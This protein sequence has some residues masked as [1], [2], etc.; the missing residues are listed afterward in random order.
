VAI[1]NPACFCNSGS[2]GTRVLLSYITRVSVLEYSIFNLNS[3]SSYDTNVF[4]LNRDVDDLSDDV[5]ILDIKGSRNKEPFI[6]EN[7]EES[8]EEEEDDEDDDF[9]YLKNKKGNMMQG[10]MNWYVV[11]ELF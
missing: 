6:E 11:T 10:L 3:Y 2:L 1:K 8:D 4:I 5:K 9:S 7:L